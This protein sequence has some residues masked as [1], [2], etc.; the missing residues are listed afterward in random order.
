MAK[1]EFLYKGD[2]IF[3]QCEEDE[4]MEEIIYKFHTKFQNQKGSVFFLYAGKI[5]D[6]DLTFNESANEIDKANKLMKVQA[7]DL[8]LDNDESKCLKKSDYIICPECKENARISVDDNYQIS[9]YECKYEHKTKNIKL[10]EFEKTQFIDESKIICDICKIENKS[11]ANGNIF[12]T[13]CT[14]KLNLCPRC[15]ISHDKK[16]YII[17]FSNKNF[18]CYTHNE[19]FICYCTDCKK[20]ICKACQNEHKNHSIITYDSITPD[21]ETSKKE[22]IYLKESIRNLRIDIKK[23][24]VKL[25]SV[26]ENLNNYYN[27]Y[28]SIINNF[29]IKKKNY[30]QIQNVN[31]LKKYNSN[32]IKNITE[33]ANDN[34][35]KTKLKDLIVLYE[36]M[37][38]KPKKYYWDFEEK[39]E[40]ENEIK[41]GNKEDLIE[42]ENYQKNLIRYNPSDNTYEN[43]DMNNL[44][45][46]KSF[47]AKYDIESLIVLHDGR[48]LVHQKFSD[49]QEKE[50]KKN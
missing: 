39:E 20:D 6:E 29:D 46:V 5:L 12:F 45:E 8:L 35:L 25:N 40:N 37:E 28:N 42:E 17:D 2:T 50:L 32:F 14:C 21:L 1:V 38:F 44:K 4:K 3:I 15:K 23:I 34:N 26:I 48:I 31:D 10:K 49:E 43:L 24:I 19:I 13:C 33:I 36:K 16:H 18:Y 7:W 9:L 41:E 47:E 30:I 11:N 27:M 22:L